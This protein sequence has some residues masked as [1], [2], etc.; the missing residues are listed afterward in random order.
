MPLPDARHP[1]RHASARAL[2]A[3]PPLASRWHWAVRGMRTAMTCGSQSVFPR[4]TGG[5]WKSGS[6]RAGSGGIQAPGRASRTLSGM[7]RRRSVAPSSPRI[8]GRR[9]D[10]QMRVPRAKIERYLSRL[11]SRSPG[12]RWSHGGIP[13]RS[14]PAV[15]GAHRG[16]Q[17]QP[18]CKRSAG[19]N[20]AWGRVSRGPYPRPRMART[21]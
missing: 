14:R 3:S 19:R 1:H 11:G 5:R 17:T 20:R 13:A 16:R 18:A 4:R 2:Q 15:A 7:T 12:E 6:G 9:G 10:V 8:L 21:G